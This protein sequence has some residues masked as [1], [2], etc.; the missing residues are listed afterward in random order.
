MQILRVTQEYVSYQ[1]TCF[2]RLHKQSVTPTFLIQQ[3]VP[4]L[5]TDVQA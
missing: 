2:D 1:Q 4:G 3:V 5:H